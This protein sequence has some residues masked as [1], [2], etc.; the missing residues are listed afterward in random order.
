MKTGAQD[1]CGKCGSPLGKPRNKGEYA[2]VA[3]DGSISGS[4]RIFAAECDEHGQVF[5]EPHIGHHSTHLEADI[6]RRYSKRIRK[7]LREILD[8]DQR[9]IFD[10]A[11]NGRRMPA[12]QD[13]ALWDKL[14]KSRI[15]G[16][17][18]G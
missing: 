14:V 17:S 10:G 16:E 1:T 6:R 4:S 13:I 3:T 11:W 7:M 8:S 12:E 2:L 9:K 18:N 5:T 15:R